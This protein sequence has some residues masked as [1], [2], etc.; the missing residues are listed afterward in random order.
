TGLLRDSARGDDRCLRA[1][2][3]RSRSLH[4]RQPV[5]L[6]G[7]P[8]LARRRD[9]GRRNLRSVVAVRTMSRATVGALLAGLALAAT[10]RPARAGEKMA[11]LVLGTSEKDAEL[12]DNLTEVL[13]A[14]VAQHGGFEIAGKEEFRARLGVE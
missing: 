2:V 8:V 1:A 10:P 11:V 3:G 13:I 9:R 4:E 6:E 7:L 14:Y 5:P 12:A